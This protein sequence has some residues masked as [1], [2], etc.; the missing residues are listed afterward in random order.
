MR[1]LGAI[2]ED[3]ITAARP[4]SSERTEATSRIYFAQGEACMRA[5]RAFFEDLI[6]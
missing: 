6:L 2:F 3:L 5:A 4:Y 1:A